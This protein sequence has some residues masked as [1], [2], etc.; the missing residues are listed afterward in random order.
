MQSLQ[1]WFVKLPKISID[2]AVMEKADNVYAIK[3]NCRWF[4]MGSFA[5][6]ADIISADRDN[7]V[8]V[9]GVSELLD[10][11]DSIIITEDEGHLIAAIG[12]KNIVIA[13]SP[14]ATL[15]C[16]VDHTQRIKELLELIK[17]N[18]GEKFL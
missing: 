1:E 10:C 12:L 4:D 18:T 7:N 17:Q 8:V 2:Y 14:D 11:K 16:H 6:L 13:H 5:A 9:A 3:L 15:I